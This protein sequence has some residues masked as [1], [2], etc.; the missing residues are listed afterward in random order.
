MKG[1]KQIN[2]HL[3][4]F[5]S[6]SA[7]ASSP[8]T[9]GSS[10]VLISLDILLFLKTKF[11]SAAKPQIN[12]SKSILFYICAV[13]EILKSKIINNNN[14]TYIISKINY[15]IYTRRFFY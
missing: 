7:A 11:V 14:D 9:E 10:V 4:F 15:N 1:R 3:D 5:T 8:L 13:K 2:S 6:T 12:F